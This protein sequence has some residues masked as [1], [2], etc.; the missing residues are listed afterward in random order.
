MFKKN[1]TGPKE[2]RTLTAE[3]ALPRLLTYCAYQERSPA[4][5]EQKMRGFGLDP[6]DQQKLLEQLHEM[7]YLNESRFVQSFT[8]GKHRLSGWGSRKISMGLA[9][10]GIDRETIKEATSTLND[11]ETYYERLLEVLQRRFVAQYH[12]LPAPEAYQKLFRM[13]ISRGYEVDLVK[14]AVKQAMMGDFEPDE[15]E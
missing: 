2:K 11:T 13:G 7:N 6:A 14:R 9:A 8:S 4:E 3:Q 15:E 5:V 12:R 1:F 10:K